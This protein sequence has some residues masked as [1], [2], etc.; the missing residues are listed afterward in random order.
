[1]QQVVVVLFYF[2]LVLFYSCGESGVTAHLAT[3]VRQM[4]CFTKSSPFCVA[5]ETLT[6]RSLFAVM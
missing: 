6:Y 2:I 1:M 4:L 5:P 3:L